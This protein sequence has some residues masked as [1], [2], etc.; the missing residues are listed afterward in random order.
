[1]DDRICIDV[2]DPAAD[3]E[4]PCVI[5]DEVYFPYV[6]IEAT[7]RS[8]GIAT[9]GKLNLNCLVDAVND[10]AATADSFN[11]H[12]LETEKH[13]VVIGNV[14]LPEARRSAQRY[15]F[16]HL[17]R[18]ARAILDFGIEL[19]AAKPVYKRF[20]IAETKAG[21]VLVDSTTGGTYALP[22]AAED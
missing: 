8:P 1:M 11:V 12:Q 13:K 7:C 16:H 15:L 4:L 22:G 3:L 17:G 10:L 6:H 19:Q 20:L 9:R 5:S 14:G 18:R 21:R 2:I